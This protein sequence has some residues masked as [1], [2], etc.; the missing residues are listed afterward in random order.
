MSVYDKLAP[1][2]QEYIY[3]NRWQELREVQVAACDIIFNTDHNLLIAT[4]T[5]SGKTEAAFLPIIT[6]IYNKPPAS[7]GVLYIAP[8]K[9]LINDQFVRIEELLDEAHIPVTKW[10]GDAS[11]TAKSRLLSLPK[12]VLQITPESLEAMLMKRKQ[13]V[14]K[15]FS[16]LRFVIIDE[17]HNFI[18]SDRGVQ[19]SSILERIQNLT[20]NTPRRIGLS[21][22][23]GDVLVAEK[24]LNNGTK[25]K[26]STPLVNEGRRKAQLMLSHFYTNKEKIDDE[27]WESYF[28]SLYQLTR[29]K[30]SIIFSNSRSEVE[31]NINRLKLIAEKK[32]ER[33]VFHVH[34]GS[35]S[36]ENREYAEEQLRTSDL[37][38]V[39]GATVTLELGIDLG[40]LERIVQTGSPHSVS[41]LSQRLGRSGR[42]SGVSQMCFVFNEDI[43]PKG[44][45]FY[46]SINWGFIK[47]I[48]LIELY[49]ENWLEP[50]RVE[51]F[52]YHI[53]FH[54]TMSVLYSFGDTSPELLAQKVLSGQ[55]FSH[56]SQDDYRELIKH[57]I[58]I[59]VLEKTQESKLAIGKKGEWLT[60]NFEFY[61]VFV[62]PVEY[63]VRD[64]V[65]EI[66]VLNQA[67]PV[68]ER[69]ILNGKT[70]EILEIDDDKKVLY[71]KFVGGKSTVNWDGAYV[72]ETHTKVLQKMR[73]VLVSGEE[74]GYLHESAA[75]RLSEIRNIIRQSDV[76]GVKHRTDVVMLSPKRFAIFPWLGS[77]AFNALD[78]TLQMYGVQVTESSNDDI[79]IC[80]N[81]SS[82]DEVY[83]VLAKIKSDSFFAEALPVSDKLIY[84]G[85]Y[86][87]FIPQSLTRKRYLDNS[88]SIVEMQSEIYLQD[89]IK[90]ALF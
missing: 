48:A 4:P 26:C 27:S 36:A 60:N 1:F 37:P 49:R 32:K 86:G 87:N 82:A 11:Q 42:R 9:A 21:A 64:G 8:L 58:E 24:W 51:Q 34:H 39:A 3:R 78:Y 18:A 61:S 20:G 83:S 68:G 52:P 63:S 15:L 28:E 45:V 72:G 66:G 54:Q 88:I 50:L 84:Q 41:S 30:K 55:T 12:G 53:L 73:E 77:R 75:N 59:E 85:K 76:F 5:A 56:I 79:F 33:D 62:V 57:L 17:V 71:V 44:E 70:W 90:D 65:Q 89:R 7:V 38:L 14:I 23:L 29:G 13:S 31:K 67:F 81:A 22:T 80:V 35:I 10:H 40:D 74:Y 16:D 6:E 69:F 25:R 47:C 43:S 2:I 19:L 46:K